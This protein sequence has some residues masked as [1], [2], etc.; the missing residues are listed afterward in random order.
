MVKLK[1]I[2]RNGVLVLRISQNKDRYYKRVGYLLTGNPDVEKH[3]LAD[4]ERFSSRSKNYE[5]NNKVLAEYKQVYW[6]L[7]TEHPE[8]SAK[9]VAEYYKGTRHT[10]SQPVE[11]SSWS[12][13]EY[14]NSVAKYLEVIT[15]REKAK[16]GC[17]YEGYYKLLNRCR[18]TIPGFDSM[19]FSTID[20]NKMVSIAYIFAK[21]KAYVHHSKKFRAL[22]GKASKDKDVMFN[23]SQIGDFQF[24]DYNP[25]KYTTDGRQHPDVLSSEELKTF[26]NFNPSDIT[27][28]YKNRKQVELYYDF[29]VFMF[30][31]FFAPCDVIKAKWRD[32]TRKNTIAVRRKKTHR[33]VEI[34]ITPVMRK[35]I[36]KYKGQSKDGYIFPIMDDEKE[37]TYNTKDYTY[38]KFR[39]FLNKWL[40]VVGK[41]L[42][43]YFDLYAYVF[44]HTAITVALDS[45]L[46]VSYI[47]EA[48]GTSI[49]MIQQHYYNGESQ[50]N[51]ERLTSAFMS[52]AQ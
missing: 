46:P 2:L 6:K 43:L 52:A 35:I 23:I 45:G 39:E 28:R 41:E 9:Q 48:A 15:L 30:H 3:W 38:K 47:A 13:E 10:G 50:S 21:E 4:K 1:F 36:D 22:L 11:L 19:P 16:S 33:P 49:E 32:I 44:R 51:R 5:E 25:D 7:V 20:Y 42:G 29:C 24:C 27:P 18:R 8:L 17:N 31:S 12:V 37:K 40:K 34:P 14:K 26:L